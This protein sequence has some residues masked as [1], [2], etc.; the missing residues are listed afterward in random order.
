MK[1]AISREP[2]GFEQSFGTRYATP[3]RSEPRQHPLKG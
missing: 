1:N 3:E 2:E